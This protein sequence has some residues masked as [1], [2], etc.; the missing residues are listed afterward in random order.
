[1]QQRRKD[2]AHVMTRSL[3]GADWR[4]FAKLFVSV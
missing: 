4:A 3:S 1:M 2:I